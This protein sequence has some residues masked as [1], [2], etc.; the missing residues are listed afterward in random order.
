L[1]RRGG[2]STYWSSRLAIISKD[3]LKVIENGRPGGEN[4]NQV[5]FWMEGTGPMYSIGHTYI[6]YSYKALLLGMVDFR[7]KAMACDCFECPH[8]LFAPLHILKAKMTLC[9]LFIRLI[10]LA[11]VGRGGAGRGKCTS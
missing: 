1:A 7:G 8:G 9:T 4:E 10:S 6:Q 2:S 5:G 11:D 3:D